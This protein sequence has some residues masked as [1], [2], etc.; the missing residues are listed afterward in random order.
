MPETRAGTSRLTAVIHG[1][2][3]KTA[4]Q[5]DYPPPETGLIDEAY[6]LIVD[7][8]HDSSTAEPFV[9]KPGEYQ[10]NRM[11]TL[12]RRYFAATPDGARTVNEIPGGAPTPYDPPPAPVPE[13][14]EPLAG[15]H[16]QYTGTGLH[17]HLILTPPELAPIQP[18][19][20]VLLVWINDGSMPVVICPIVDSSFYAAVAPTRTTQEYG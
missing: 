2:A 5:L 10:L 15:G 6:N 19:D 18:W 8:S 14:P 13:P 1:M 9:F 4:G 7:R 17:Q 11:L 16:A 20:R 3:R 12:P